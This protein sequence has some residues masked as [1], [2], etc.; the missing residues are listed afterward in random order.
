M[1]RTSDDTFCRHTRHLPASGA[2][3]SE[4]QW[5]ADIGREL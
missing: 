3:R 1:E 2:E 4:A 5:E